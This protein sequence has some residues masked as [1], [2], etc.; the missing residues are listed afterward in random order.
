MWRQDLPVRMEVFSH[1]GWLLRSGGPV[2]R[3]RS[4]DR[5]VSGPRALQ[6]AS[7]GF[8]ALE[9]TGSKGIFD[10][11]MQCLIYWDYHTSYISH[12]FS[13]R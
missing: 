6:M 13:S 8:G 11:G 3:L 10:H 5:S 2:C 12:S 9:S 4:A 7:K 1:A